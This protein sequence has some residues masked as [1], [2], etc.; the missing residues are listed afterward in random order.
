MKIIH[1]QDNINIRLAQK[2]THEIAYKN[3]GVGRSFGD[4][5]AWASLIAR[6]SLGHGGI[7]IRVNRPKDS[8]KKCWNE[9]LDVGDARYKVDNKS[10]CYQFRD[11]TNTVYAWPFLKAKKTYDISKVD[12][13]LITYQ[14]K[15]PKGKTDK[16]L[17]TGQEEIILLKLKEMGYTTIELGA[18]NSEEQNLTYAATCKFFVGICSGMSHLCHSIGTPVHL[19]HNDMSLYNIKKFHKNYLVNYHHTYLDFLQYMEHRTD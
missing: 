5:L 9:I 16:Q 11:W 17:K 3:P 6:I 4:C 13:S 10:E 14:F 15:S 19:I 7:P 2:Y 12:N 8:F 1:D 18:N